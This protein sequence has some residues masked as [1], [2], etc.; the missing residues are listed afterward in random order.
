MSD[1]I[2]A[3]EREM[4]DQAIKDGM[5]NVIP[6]GVSG[7]DH[8]TI[9]DERKNKLVFTDPEAARERVRKRMWA[10]RKKDPEVAKRRRRIADLVVQGYTGPE[11]AQ[12]LNIPQGTVGSD[13]ERFGISIPRRPAGQKKQLRKVG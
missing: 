8:E 5:V 9:W 6:K 12:M 7:E 10:G 1:E 2:T 3:K 11:I 13:A 4:I